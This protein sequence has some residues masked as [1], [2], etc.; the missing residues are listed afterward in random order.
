MLALRAAGGAPRRRARRLRWLARQQDRD[1]GFSFAGRGGASDVDDTGAALE[2]LAGAAAPA[3]R[4]VARASR[5]MRRQQNR[6]GG[7]PLAAGRGLQRAVDGVGGPGLLA[8]GV[9]PAAAPRGASPLA[10]LRR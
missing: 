8:A 5:Y 10:Y 7:F 3:A 4:A 2:A 1:G 6:D 9:N